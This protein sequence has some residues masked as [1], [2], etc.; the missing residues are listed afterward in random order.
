MSIL[1]VSPSEASSE[2]AINFYAIIADQFVNNPEQVIEPSGPDMYEKLIDF[3]WEDNQITKLFGENNI[4]E[5]KLRSELE[6]FQSEI[7]SND[8]FFLYLHGHGLTYLDRVLNIEDWLREELKNINTDNK[9][10]IIDACHSGNFIKD[11]NGISGF[12]M[13]SVASDEYGLAMTFEE[14]DW[15][16]SEPYFKGSVNSHFWITRLNES[17]ADCS[18]DG[19]ITMKEL[20]KYTLPQIQLLYKEFFI[21]YPDWAEDPFGITNPDKETYP[22]PVVRNRLLYSIS[23]NVSHFKTNVYRFLKAKPILYTS[24]SIGGVVV[25]SLFGVIVY[26]NKIRTHILSNRS[27]NVTKN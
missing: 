25:F 16:F 17:R 13:S 21:A 19:V 27:K 24:I 2:T 15:S 22:N 14:S 10:I 12:L 11:L 1:F 9:I 8:L 7:D 18:G 6:R 3:G 20:Y 4:T 26:R 5:S 23:L